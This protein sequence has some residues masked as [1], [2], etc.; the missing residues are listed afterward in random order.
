MSARHGLA[1]ALRISRCLL[2]PA[3]MGSPGSRPASVPD[4]GACGGTGNSGVSGLAHLVL[5]LRREVERKHVSA[6]TKVNVHKARF[7]Q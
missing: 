6:G 1:E 5:A 4:T 2:W 7:S 3:D